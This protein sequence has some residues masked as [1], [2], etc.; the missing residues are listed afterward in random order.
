MLIIA[1]YSNIFLFLCNTQ[2]IFSPKFLIKLQMEKR[3]G[4]SLAQRR[5]I[6]PEEFIDWSTFSCKDDV[7]GDEDGS[8]EP[9]TIWI[10][11]KKKKWL[12]IEKPDQQIIKDLV[13]NSEEYVLEKQPGEDMTGRRYSSRN[14]LKISRTRLYLALLTSQGYLIPISP[15]SVARYSYQSYCNPILQY[16]PFYVFIVEHTMHTKRGDESVWGPF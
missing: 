4:K 2:T 13:I 9:T 6:Q 5:E 11:K 12:P 15:K 1:W 16:N 8:K 3:R 14:H 10:Y 7:I